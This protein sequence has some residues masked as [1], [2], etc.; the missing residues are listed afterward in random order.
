VSVT[1]QEESRG[2]Y[3]GLIDHIRESLTETAESTAE[4]GSPWEDPSVVE[5]ATAHFLPPG[6]RDKLNFGIADAEPTS[7]G[8]EAPTTDLPSAEAQPGPSGEIR[9]W[10]EAMDVDELDQ[11]VTAIYD[12]RYEKD[13]E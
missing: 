5:R 3:A 8:D 6:E 4:P 12:V 1:K 11:L 2:G 9:Q 13:A 7:S 10:L